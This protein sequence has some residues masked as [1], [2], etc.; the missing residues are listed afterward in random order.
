[1][2]LCPRKYWK[3]NG[4]DEFPLPISSTFSYATCKCHANIGVV[5]KGFSTKA[6]AKAGGLWVEKSG[7]RNQKPG[8][9]PVLK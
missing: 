9:W 8:L 7:S 2:I 6:S 3:Q 5:K 1:M 4:N